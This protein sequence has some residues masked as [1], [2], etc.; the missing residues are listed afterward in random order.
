MS[1]EISKIG[2]L[3]SMIQIGRQ[4]QR[5]ALMDAIIMPD[6]ESRYFS[7]NKK[8]SAVKGEM[9]ASMRDG[10]GGEYFLHFSEN[11]VVGKVFD[12]LPLLDFK[13]FLNCI[14][15]CF[16]D[17]KSEVAFQL[18]NA[19]F[20]FW[21]AKGFEWVAAPS[22]LENYPNLRF[23]VEGVDYY[24]KWAEDYYERD[25]NLRVLGEVFDCLNI[26]QQQLAVLNSDLTIKDLA[27][28]LQEILG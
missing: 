19:S 10:F 25:I 7:F 24:H 2:D 18:S 14:P 28:D 5:L 22:N 23:L 21:Q 4:A 26:T 13:G 15:D 11:G 1:H 8:W 3:P 16:S 17:F 6:W 9:M 20:Y 27:E 12:E